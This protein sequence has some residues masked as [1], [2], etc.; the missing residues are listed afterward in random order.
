V[1]IQYTTRLSS[2]KLTRLLRRLNP[3]VSSRRFRLAVAD[4]ADA[5][6]LGGFAHNAISPMGMREA[7][8]F[9][10]SAEMRALEHP[11]VWF[12]GG[13]VDVKLGVQLEELIE[14]LA[15][16]VIVADIT[17]RHDNDHDHDHTD[18]DHNNDCD[19]IVRVS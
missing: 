13:A 9:V 12:G 17:V 8:P 7:I 5:Y 18:H 2:V 6:R 14:V 19:E 4:Q 1:L 15:D 11:F 16:R 3:L 10:L